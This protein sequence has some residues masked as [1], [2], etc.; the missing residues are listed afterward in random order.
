MLFII[1]FWNDSSSIGIQ[2]K[3]KNKQT[4][5]QTESQIYPVPKYL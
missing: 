2:T 4:N 1:F 3:P 5:K